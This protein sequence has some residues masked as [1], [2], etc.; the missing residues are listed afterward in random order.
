MAPVTV[1]NSMKTLVRFHS[2]YLFTGHFPLCQPVKYGDYKLL[3]YNQK[4]TLLS[5]RR[6]E[7]ERERK[8]DT[9]GGRDRLTHVVKYKYAFV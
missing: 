2:Y 4:L 1:N 6:K 9:H 8:D 3:H 7:G 5:L